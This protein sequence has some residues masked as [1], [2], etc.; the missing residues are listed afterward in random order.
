MALEQY[1]RRQKIMITALIVVIAAMFTVTGSLTYML[2]DSSKTPTK[3]G[4]MDGREYNYIKFHQRLRQ[5]L[6]ACMYLD[7]G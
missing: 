6:N 4:Q 7:A 5:G 3:A 1:N 2:G